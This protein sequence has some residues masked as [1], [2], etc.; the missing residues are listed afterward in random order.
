MVSKERARRFYAW[1][2]GVC[3]MVMELIELIDER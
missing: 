3:A 1:L 2:A